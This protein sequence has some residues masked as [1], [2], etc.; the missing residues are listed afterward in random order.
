MPAADGFAPAGRHPK[1]HA[2]EHRGADH[3]R[4]RERVLLSSPSGTVPRANG[5][6]FMTKR[7]RLLLAF[8]SVSLPVAGC[9][10]NVT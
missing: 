4:A 6:A 10:R 2:H 9:L 8:A 5:G 7:G 3:D 1:R